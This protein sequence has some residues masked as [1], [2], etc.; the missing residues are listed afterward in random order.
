MKG[1]DRSTD[2]SSHHPQGA[3]GGASNK[4]RPIR[5]SAGCQGEACHNGPR[6]ADAGGGRAAGGK[7]CGGRQKAAG[8]EPRATAPRI[9]RQ[10]PARRKVVRGGVHPRSRCSDAPMPVEPASAQVLRGC[11]HHSPPEKDSAVFGGFRVP[12]TRV[13]EKRRPPNFAKSENTVP[14]GKG[15]AHP[16]S[17]CSDAGPTF[18]FDRPK[19]AQSYCIGEPG[20]AGPKSPRRWPP[21]R[22]PDLAKFGG[23]RFPG[24]RDPEKTPPPK[25]AK[26]GPGGKWCVGSA[27]PK[28]LL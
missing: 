3:A 17:T 19:C 9:F 1:Q 23:R 11:A 12:G 2:Q 8:L 4:G 26:S 22:F 28:Y 21:V 13:P 20:P 18:V 10:V 27:P 6:P 5:A 7:L 15:C 16:R 14:G 25:T 24:A